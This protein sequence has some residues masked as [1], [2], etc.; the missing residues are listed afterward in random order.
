MV[1]FITE[2]NE[3]FQS[4]INESEVKN[5][6]VWCLFHFLILV[7]ASQPSPVCLPLAFFVATLPNEV[8]D[9]FF[10]N[11]QLDQAE[12]V[13]L[14]FIFYVPLALAVVYWFNGLFLLTCDYLMPALMGRMRIQETNKLNKMKVLKLV[15]VIAFHCIVMIPLIGYGVWLMHTN[16]SFSVK[17]TRE[18]P[19]YMERCLHTALTVF[20]FNETLFFYGHWFFHANKW[21]YKNIHKIHHEFTAPNALAAIYC[22]PIELVVADFI[23]LGIGPFVLNGHLYTFLAWAVFAVLGT[24][25]HHCGFKWPWGTW[26]HQPDYHDLHHEKFNGNYGNI[27]WLDWLHGTKFPE[28]AKRKKE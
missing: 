23:P 14:F 17:M 16:T 9:K 13:Q 15:A 24:Q 6:W 21:C 1:Q 19:S 22:H 26:D 18:L 28:K 7:G 8:W 4:W 12:G 5:H 10:D 20:V 2:T 27:G 11:F 3:V 25:T